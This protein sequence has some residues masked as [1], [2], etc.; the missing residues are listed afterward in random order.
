MYNYLYFF[1]ASKKEPF[2]NFEI[3]KYI[4]NVALISEPI[5][6]ADSNSSF[7]RVTRNS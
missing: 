7:I 6:L 2:W 3:L 5:I 4:G 1:T